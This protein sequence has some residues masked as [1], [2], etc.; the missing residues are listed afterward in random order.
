M[1][2]TSDDRHVQAAEA[3][4]RTWKGSALPARETARQRL[5]THA[6]AIVTAIITVIYLVWRLLVTIDPGSY[7]LGIP[8][9]IAETWAF[10][11]AILYFFVLWD[12]D[13]IDAP[14]RRQTDEDVVTVLIP[15]YN[16]PVEVVLPVIAAAQAMHQVAAV[17]VLDDGKREWLRDLCADMQVVYRT[18][19]DHV[20][21]KA[22]NIN[23]A[24]PDVATPFIIVLD[25]DH[26]PSQDFVARLIGY[27]DDPKVAVVQTPQDFY[28]QDSFE[29]EMLRDT[30][31]SEE[32]LFYRG[33]LTGRNRWNAAFWCGTSA[34]LRVAALREVG[35]IATQSI[36]EDILTTINLHKAGWK[37]VHHNEVLARG[38]AAANADQYLTQRL[39]WG[40]GAMQV[41]RRERFMTRG[42]LSFPQRVS[43]LSTLTGW[44]DSWRE[45][46][47]LIIPAL[48]LIFA[49][50]VLTGPWL[51]FVILFVTTWV[52]QRYALARIGRGKASFWTSTV[53]DIIRLPATMKATTSIVWMRKL[54]FKVTAKG[55]QADTERSR[56]KEPRLFIFTAAL[57]VLAEVVFALDVLGVID[58]DYPQMSMAWVQAGWCLFNLAIV[59]AAIRR[60]RSSRFASDRRASYRVDVSGDVFLNDVQCSAADL[61]FGGALVVSPV[62]YER[63]AD[64][65]FSARGE[66]LRATVTN[67]TVRESDYVIS[68]RF[69]PGQEIAASRLVA[70]ALV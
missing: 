17:W 7:P 4:W 66:T 29:H 26:V 2:G 24:L 47:L 43:Y 42:K 9:W 70:P 67:R 62:E 39:R 3:P 19:P 37:S 11:T 61:S 15:T 64:V 14:A 38:L 36:T 12:L 45:Y 6:V 5:L 22:G 52:M 21:A 54:Q 58:Q 56:N 31:F 35:G 18:R 25:A 55:R 10:G 23:A 28:N 48:S 53:F 1:R 40:Q 68:I 69:Y 63:F 60:V 41:L 65:T 27:F 51:P 49:Q 30:L 34:M 32:E 16:E 46:A 33:M 50:T 13:A 20:D 57:L 59:A 44:F 8:L